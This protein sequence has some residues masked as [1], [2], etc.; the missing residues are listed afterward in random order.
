MFRMCCRIV[1]SIVLV[2]HKQFIWRPFVQ[3][4]SFNSAYTQH[5]ISSMRT[6]TYTHHT[7]NTFI[8]AYTH[9]NIKKLNTNGMQNFNRWL[10]SWVRERTRV[11][12]QCSSSLAEHS[13]GF[14]SIKVAQKGNCSKSPNTLKSLT[15]AG[16]SEF[17]TYFS[18]IA[19][20]SLG[21]V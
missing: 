8:G 18:V 20:D 2:C 3:K 1:N 17:V 16:H 4:S 15:I 11:R 7:R 9:N 21:L 14:T 12:S 10:H 5:A 19:F 13:Y 6:Q